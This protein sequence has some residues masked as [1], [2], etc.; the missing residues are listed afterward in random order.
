MDEQNAATASAIE[1]CATE[2][3]ELAR[4]RFSVVLDY[5][6]ESLEKLEGI[7]SQQYASIP[8]GWRRWFRRGPSS[9]VID[10]FSK[11]WGA[12]AGEVLRRKWGG[13]WSVPEHG[14]FAGV[15]TL[16]VQGQTISPP[17]KV[18]KRLMNGDEDNLWFYARVLAK[19]FSPL[20]DEDSR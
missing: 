11:I 20:R 7:L 9:D 16:T 8:K 15:I 3:I 2:A 4:N 13:F 17:A 14:P 12:Y 1:A 10:Q 18:C 5:S 6:F 19:D